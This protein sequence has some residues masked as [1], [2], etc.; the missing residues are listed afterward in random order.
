MDG[1]A[2]ETALC[3]GGL[4]FPLPGCGRRLAPWGSGLYAALV[5]GLGGVP[6]FH[7]AA[8][9]AQTVDHLAAEKHE[10]GRA[11]VVAVDEAHLLRRPARVRRQH[12]VEGP[13]FSVTLQLHTL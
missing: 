10:R 11:V 2:V 4:G 9:I 12:R 13:Q 8:L 5:S 6:R 3:A 7:T 1:A